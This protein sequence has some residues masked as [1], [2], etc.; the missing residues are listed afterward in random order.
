MIAEVGVVAC[1]DKQG[2]LIPWLGLCLI[3]ETTDGIVGISYTLVY[4][5]S[6]LLIYV[7]VFLRHLVG[8]MG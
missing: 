1:D 2:V 3:E 5:N 8:M 7:L 6:F 4:Y